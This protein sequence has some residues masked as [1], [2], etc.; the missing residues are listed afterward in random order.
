M[1]MLQ[2]TI[3]GR[4]TSLASRTISQILAEGKN[5]GNEQKGIISR[6][7]KLIETQFQSE[8]LPMEFLPFMPKWH[9]AR[10]INAKL[11]ECPPHG[12]PTS[13]AAQASVAAHKN[14]NINH[15]TQRRINV[16]SKWDHRWEIIGSGMDFVLIARPLRPK[17]EKRK[18]ANC[19]GITQPFLNLNI[20]FAS[21]CLLQIH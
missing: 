8:K 21:N 2:R 14:E 18:R 16:S 15:R 17:N 20:I 1:G 9:Y 10:R 5:R 19:S 6:L 11:L 3:S 13:T 7:P 12:D 4:G